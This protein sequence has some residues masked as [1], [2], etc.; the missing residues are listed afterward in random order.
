VDDELDI[1]NLM[2]VFLKN[3]GYETTGARSKEELL[4]TL[5]EYD[6]DLI[7]LDVLLG[8]HDGREICQEINAAKNSQ[9][10]ILLYSAN[11]QMLLNYPDCGASDV[12]EKPFSL[13]TLHEK[14]EGLLNS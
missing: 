13:Y 12:L 7:I 1:L 3:Q 14:V 2:T 10:P 8:A 9:I 6:P 4:N 11:A 5:P